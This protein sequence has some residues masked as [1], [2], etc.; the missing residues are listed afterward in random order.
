MDDLFTA[1]PDVVEGMIDI[2]K[3]W[4]SNYD[5]A[6]FRIDTMK[7]VNIE[8]WQ[9]FAQ[10]LLEHAAAEGK[11]DFFFFGEVFSGNEDLLSYY[12]TQ[13]D[14]PA[15]LD[16]KYQEHIRAYASQ[17]QSAQIL[18][19]LFEDDDVFI[20]ADSNATLLPLFTGNHDRG[21]F[22]YFLVADSG[23]AMSEDEML[24]RS[25]LAH[26]MMYF[27]RGVPV[28]YYGDEQGFTG[29]GGDK[30]ARQDMFPSQVAEYNDPAINNMIGTDATPADDNFD[31]THP[32]Y[33]AFA[34]LRRSTR[35]TTACARARRSTATP[36]TARAS[37][38]SAAWTGRAS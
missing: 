16:F 15:V 36:P 12:M 8:F 4:I 26:A 37:T 30:D 31:T 27:A 13:T 24:A 5:I 10:A 19:N 3:D 23:G 21:R 17:Q 22:G 38:P 2:Y 25:T 28:I 7:H 18:Q 32:L 14:V 29:T 34:E 11:D 1:H 20:D 9:P 35:P 33:Q 6:G